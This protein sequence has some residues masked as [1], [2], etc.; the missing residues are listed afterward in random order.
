MSATSKTTCIIF[1]LGGL[2]IIAL[3]ASRARRSEMSSLPYFR[4]AAL[5]PE[6][7]SD[8]EASSTST[9]RIAAFAMT[10]QHGA[11]VSEKALRSHVTIAQFFFTKCGDVC[12]TTTGNIQRLLSAVPDSALQVF[13]YSVTPGRDSVAALRDY[14]ARRGIHDPR[15][16]LLTGSDSAIARLARDS[17]FVR[18]GDGA[19]YGVS[20]IAHTETLVLVDG[21]G[22]IRGFYAGTLP[23]EMHRLQGDAETLLHEMHVARNRTP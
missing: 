7:L 5:T 3:G 1:A 11:A 22:R 6:W 13:S 12:P 21:E 14:A 19:S 10:D 17:Y 2:C 15:W 18:L 23:L 16:R 20:T 8:A 9:H 4:S